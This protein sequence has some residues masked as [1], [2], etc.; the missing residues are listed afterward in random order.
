MW[1]PGYSLL[2]PAVIHK[3][4]ISVAQENKSLLLLVSHPMIVQAGGLVFQARELFRDPGSQRLC[5]RLFQVW[6]PKVTTG[7]C[8]QINIQS[9]QEGSTWG[10]VRRVYGP[11]IKT[12][13]TFPW[14]DLGHMAPP[15]HNRD[16]GK[17]HH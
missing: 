4:Q 5:Q 14:L 1:L 8:V 15:R 13:P 3:A 10:V 9:A 12:V 7:I 17:C 11:G 16:A 6:F 2:T